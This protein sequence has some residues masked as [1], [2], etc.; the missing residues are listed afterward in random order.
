[1]GDVNRAAAYIDPDVTLRGVPTRRLRTMQDING[2]VARGAYVMR[3]GVRIRGV[4]AVGVRAQGIDGVALYGPYLDPAVLIDGVPTR[5]WRTSGAIPA[6]D[7][8]YPT[9][10]FRG[11]TV[12]KSIKIRFPCWPI[13]R[14]LN[15]TPSPA[16]A[17]KAA[18]HAQNGFGAEYLRSHTVLA[19]A[20]TFQDACRVYTTT[21]VGRQYTLSMHVGCDTSDKDPK[22]GWQCEYLMEA[23]QGFPQFGDV[24]YHRMWPEYGG[25]DVDGSYYMRL[26]IARRPRDWDCNEPGNWDGNHPAAWITNTS[27]T[28]GLAAPWEPTLWVGDHDLD[29]NANEPHPFHFNPT[30]WPSEGYMEFRFDSNEDLLSFFLTP[31]PIEGWLAKVSPL[32]AS[33]NELGNIYPT[34]LAERDALGP[35]T[36]WIV[37]ADYGAPI[38]TQT[39]P[40]QGASVTGYVAVDDPVRPAVDARDCAAAAAVDDDAPCSHGVFELEPGHGACCIIE[41]FV[42]P[43]TEPTTQ[44]VGSLTESECAALADDQHETWWN[45]GALCTPWPCGSQPEDQGA[46]CLPFGGCMMTTAEQCANAGGQFLGLDRSCSEVPDPCNVQP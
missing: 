27:W 29:G 43:Q 20:P 10:I 5:R 2:F 28:A 34:P 37:G 25:P 41:T 45:E 42:D 23:L 30:R 1:M 3:A 24:E 15:A 35:F 39:F 21:G 9:V 16:K 12:P 7:F 6:F 46:C 44:C 13:M 14:P 38:A 11:I 18:W 33:G 26:H 31:Y 40:F 22:N 17:Y 4:P 19:D 32:A 36:I 8:P